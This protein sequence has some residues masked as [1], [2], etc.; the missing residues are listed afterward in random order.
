PATT[1]R[2]QGIHGQ[3]PQRGGIDHRWTVRGD[4][5]AA[6]RLFPDRGGRP[7]GGG[8]DRGGMAIGADRHDRGA[9][10]GRSVA[11]RPPIRLTLS[12]RKRWPRTSYLTRSAMNTRPQRPSSWR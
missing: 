6:R 12:Q 5:G 1:E 4:E 3:G 11:G 10:G 7:E 9:A 2:A 8:A